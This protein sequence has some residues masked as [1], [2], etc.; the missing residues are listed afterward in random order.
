MSE[1][2]SDE[3]LAEITERHVGPCTDKGCEWFVIIAELD[4]LKAENTRLKA[5]VAKLSP[6]GM[7]VTDQHDVKGTRVTELVTNG[8]GK[9]TAFKKEDRDA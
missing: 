7:T 2:L 1:P 3:R 9:A 4:R 8:G 6:E 5:L